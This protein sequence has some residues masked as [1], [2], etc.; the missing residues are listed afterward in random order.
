MK[1][2]MRISGF[3]TAM[4]C[5]IHVYLWAFGIY[6]PKHDWFGE[7]LLVGYVSAGMLLAYSFLVDE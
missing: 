4:F 5:S 6:E 7:T 2:Y 3:V 1:K